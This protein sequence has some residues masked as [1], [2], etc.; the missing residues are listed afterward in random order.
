MRHSSRL[1]QIGLVCCCLLVGSILGSQP[2]EAGPWSQGPG[3]FYLKANETFMFGKESILDGKPGGGDFFGATTALY[4]EVGIFY[5]LQFQFLLPY[6]VIKITR[7]ENEYYQLDSFL[8]SIVG[9]QWTP[10]F[11]QKAIGFPIAIRFNTKIPLYNQQSL[12][13]D[14]NSKAVLGRFPI[15]GEGQLDFTLWLSVGGSIPNTNLYLFGEVGYRFRSEIFLDDR[16]KAL[17]LS[18]LDTFVFNTQIG[19]FI[20]R[21]VLVMVNFNGA[22]P[23]GEET[24]PVSKGF[25][26]IGLGLYIP[27]WKG[28]AFEA[29]FDHMVWSVAA[30][31]VTGFNLGL[32]Y[33]F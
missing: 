30:P 7:S 5:G 10:P 4:G 31:P 6:S 28:L 20:L 9:I 14:E 16:I 21:K 1:L 19:Y 13:E 17:T 27:V 18:F 22:I 24:G 2:C 3:H 25:V 23:L 29:G 11:L 15:L 12:T 33:K 8:D 26:G 32:S